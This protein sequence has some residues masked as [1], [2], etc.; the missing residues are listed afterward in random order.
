M[1]T[2]GDVTLPPYLMWQD[3]LSWSAVD[4]QEEFSVTGALLLDID[5]KQAGRPITLV[6]D[7]NR[8]WILRDTLLALFALVQSPQEL[9]LDYH[10]RI[11]QVRF[12]YGSGAPVA[13]EPLVM[14]IPPKS[15]DKYHSLT[16]KLMEV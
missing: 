14:R 10:G 12:R 16:I 9:T 3:E 1:I 8:G 15:T 4:Q 7:K 13:A 5:V 6:G 2:L 11:F